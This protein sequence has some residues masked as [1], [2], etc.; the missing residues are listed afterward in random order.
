MRTKLFFASM[1]LAV[2]CLTGCKGNGNDPDNNGNSGNSG[3]AGSIAQMNVPKLVEDIYGKTEAEIAA[4]LEKQGFSHHGAQWIWTSQTIEQAPA[5]KSAEYATWL[6]K[7][8]QTLN[9]GLISI[10]V[11]QNG[12]EVWG[13]TT[14]VYVPNSQISDIYSKL[15]NDAYGL[16]SSLGYGAYINPG[17]DNSI[18]TSYADCSCAMYDKLGEYMGIESEADCATHNEFVKLVQ[19]RLQHNKIKLTDRSS[20]DVC[21][22]EYCIFDYKKTTSEPQTDGYTFEV[23][24]G[25]D[26]EYLIDETYKVEIDCENFVALKYFRSKEEGGRMGS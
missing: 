17:Y 22:A 18:S 2:L 13:V 7:T 9:D 11:E 1:V 15:S 6:E 25:D 16:K 8:K 20:W 24:S 26:V 5:E 21:W 4:I 14:N 3:N 19:N 10:Q 12:N 23:V